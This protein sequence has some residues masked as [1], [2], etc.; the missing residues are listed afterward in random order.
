MFLGYNWHCIRKDK[1]R[2]IQYLFMKKYIAFSSYL[3][4]D[5]E[6]LWPFRP[7]AWECEWIYKYRRLVHVYW[8]KISLNCRTYQSIDAFLGRVNAINL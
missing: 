4:K 6:I 1:E 8:R 5:V 3:L 7:L 2:K